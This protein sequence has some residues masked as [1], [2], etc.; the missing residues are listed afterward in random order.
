MEGSSA[1]QPV[2]PSDVQRTHSTALAFSIVSVATF[3]VLPPVALGFGIAALV[4]VRKGRRQSIAAGEQPPR[5]FGAQLA[6]G[7]I[8]LIGSI[9]VSIVFIASIAA[10][11]LSLGA[12]IGNTINSQNA[13]GPSFSQFEAADKTFTTSEVIEYGPYDLKVRDIQKAYILSPEEAVYIDAEIEDAKQDHFHSE[14]DTYG[15]STPTEERVYTKFTIDLAYN[16]ERG[17]TYAKIMM[18]VSS[19]GDGLANL[20]LDDTECI[21]RS[22]TNKQLEVYNHQYSDE[23]LNPATITYICIGKTATPKEASLDVSAFS[24]VSAIVGTEGMPRKSFTYL[25][26]F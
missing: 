16:A 17:P 2:T 22:L 8:G 7:L 5:R 13:Y 15:Q 24:K 12:V 14:Y 1:S 21:A 25:I 9:I 23:Y 6:M 11:V 10:A 3:F 4:K 18:D 20:A 19:W 26:E